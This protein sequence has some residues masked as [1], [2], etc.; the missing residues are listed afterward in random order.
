M[1]PAEFTAWVAH[2]KAARQWKQADCAE[3]LS[4]DPGQ[5]T[6]WKANGAPTYIGLAIAAI[7]SI[8][9]RSRS[10]LKL[11]SSVLNPPYPRAAGYHP[12]A[13]APPIAETKASV[14]RWRLPSGVEITSRA[15]KGIQNTVICRAA[16][17]RRA[18]RARSLSRD[19]RRLRHSN[20]FRTGPRRAQAH[21]SAML[22]Q[23][24]Q[25]FQIL[26]MATAFS[27]TAKATRSIAMCVGDEA[28]I[29]R[30]HSGST[31]PTTNYPNRD[32]RLDAKTSAYA[33][34]FVNRRAIRAAT[35]EDIASQTT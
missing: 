3:A 23:R 10:F 15:L 14:P 35:P 11:K 12:A 17:S 30:P 27:A 2:A 6:R 18:E 7:E 31:S 33:Q 28:I 16:F 24:R 22:L 20:R 1:T 26:P 21:E 9:I 32:R 13:S 29:P 5:I 8:F 25:P 4:V 19:A 34:C